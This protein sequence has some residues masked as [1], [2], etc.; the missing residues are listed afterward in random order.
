[1]H[2][3]WGPVHMQ[4]HPVCH[5][6]M[7]GCHAAITT[8]AEAGQHDDPVLMHVAMPAAASGG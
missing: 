4:L 6:S 3:A 5:D 7:H 2:S 1:M 8:L